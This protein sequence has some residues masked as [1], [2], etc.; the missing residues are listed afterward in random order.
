MFNYGDIDIPS[1]KTYTY[2]GIIFT[3]SGSLKNTQQVLRQKGLRAYFG[4][5]KY[6]DLRNVLTLAAL[7]LYDALVQPVVTHG[8]QIW[9]PGTEICKSIVG[10]KQP[11]SIMGNITSDPL[12]RVHLSFF[13]WSV[14]KQTSNAAVYGDC[15]GKP[16]KQFMDFLNRLTLL[17]RNGSLSIVRHAFA[18]QKRLNL[19]WYTNTVQ[20]SE[21]LGPRLSYIVKGRSD[22]LPNALLCKTNAEKWFKFGHQNSRKTESSDTTAT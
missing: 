11:I 7:K 22:M 20:L 8:F 17:D 6:I 16:T 15:G 10:V 1:V 18:E 21:S 14:S 3:L 13:K 19:P 5:K 4:M 2:L 12:E 9:L